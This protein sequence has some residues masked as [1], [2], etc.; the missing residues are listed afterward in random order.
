MANALNVVA[1]YVAMNRFAWLN[2]N[3][4]PSSFDRENS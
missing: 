2:P 1:T 4:T 3:Q